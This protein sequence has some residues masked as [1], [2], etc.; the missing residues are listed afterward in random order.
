MDDL[1]GSSGIG[2]ASAGTIFSTPLVL[3]EMS[4]QNMATKTLLPSQEQPVAAGMDDIPGPSDIQSM[5]LKEEKTSE[6]ALLLW[7][8]RGEKDCCVGVLCA[9]GSREM[10]ETERKTQTVIWTADQP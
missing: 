6:P 9:A 1:F 10:A 3:D 2:S 4:S 7:H 5:V 8:L